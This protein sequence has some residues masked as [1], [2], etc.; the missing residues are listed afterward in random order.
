MEE[1]SQSSPQSPHQSTHGATGRVARAAHEG[2]DRVARRGE[3]AEDYVREMGSAASD[4]SRRFA[5]EV[6]EY[7][8]EHPYGAMGV[9]MAAGILIGALLRRD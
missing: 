5:R 1:E 4:R 8:Q 2:I 6:T 3:R 7:V 9:A